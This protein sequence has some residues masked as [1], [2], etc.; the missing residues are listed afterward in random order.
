VSRA[1]RCGPHMMSQPV[2]STTPRHAWGLGR[3]QGLTCPPLLPAWL[4]LCL[5]S[6]Q[7][8]LRFAPPRPSGLVVPQTLAAAVCSKARARRTASKLGELCLL[9]IKLVVP[10][11]VCCRQQAKHAIDKGRAHCDLGGRLLHVHG[12]RSR[13]VLTCPAPSPDTSSGAVLAFLGAGVVAS[14]VMKLLGMKESGLLRL[15]SSII[16]P[17]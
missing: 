10:Q 14:A 6:G 3:Q 11:H 4:P 1:R 16:R 9:F 12:I 5:S 7:H 15:A 13:Q 8:C 17:S 2:L